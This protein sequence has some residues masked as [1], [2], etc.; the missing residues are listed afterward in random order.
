M[1]QV[2]WLG[3]TEDGLARLRLTVTD[4]SPADIRLY[5]LHLDM[6]DPWRR[7]CANFEGELTYIVITQPGQPVALHLRVGLDLLR[8]FEL[9]L[10]MENPP[11]ADN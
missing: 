3:T 5:C 4:E 9:V 11:V 7:T 1:Q 2:E 8:P 10:E 6:D